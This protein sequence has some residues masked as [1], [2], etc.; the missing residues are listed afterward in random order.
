MFVEICD[1]F[2]YLSLVDL[3][4]IYRVGIYEANDGRPMAILYFKNK[5]TMKTYV[6]YNYMRILLGVNEKDRLSKNQRNDR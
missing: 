5:T 2:E 6:T 1:E 4:E 3:D